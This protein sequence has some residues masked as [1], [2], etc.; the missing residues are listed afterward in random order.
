MD[1]KD[2]EL[3]SSRWWILIN[4]IICILAILFLK[5]SWKKKNNKD[6]G[7]RNLPDLIFVDIIMMSG[8]E[9]PQKCRQVCQSWNMMIFVMTSNE[10]DTIRR[11]ADIHACRIR[12]DWVCLAHR[13]R[14]P[15]IVTAASLAHHGVLGEVSR[16]RLLDVDLA[17][18]QAEHLA[19]LAS[20]VTKSVSISNVQ[21]LQL[22]P[23]L[24]NIKCDFLWIYK[25][26][27]NGEE[28]GALNRA[29]EANVKTV[30]SVFPRVTRWYG[31]KNVPNT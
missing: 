7:W 27:L 19:A 16:L 24:D 26:S 20:C 1:N 31:V 17:S 11:K 29:M 15:E 8:L 5:H 30:S 21:N 3:I 25:Q 2:E 6:A 22:I 23:I 13:P 12:E 4:I 9:D 28:I 10:I 14:L 18:V